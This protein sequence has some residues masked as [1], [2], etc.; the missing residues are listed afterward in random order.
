MRLTLVDE[1]QVATREEGLGKISPPLILH[2]SAIGCSHPGPLSGHVQQK[3]IS[4]TSTPSSSQLHLG[5]NNPLLQHSTETCR[6]IYAYG[7]A[8]I[9]KIQCYPVKISVP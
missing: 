5:K 2:L 8:N 7:I 1:T 9:I 3:D 4:P 6:L